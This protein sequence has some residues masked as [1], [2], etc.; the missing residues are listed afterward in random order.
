MV[1]SRLVSSDKLTERQVDAVQG[2]AG[3]HTLE[4]A[5]EAPNEHPIVVVAR[6]DHSSKPGSKAV[7]DRAPSVVMDAPTDS[8]SKSNRDIR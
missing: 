1:Y 4:V 8:D 5:Y 2:Y 3:V 7:K 6:G